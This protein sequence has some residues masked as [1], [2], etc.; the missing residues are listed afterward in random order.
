[1]IKVLLIVAIIGVNSTPAVTLNKEFLSLEDCIK[2]GQV[3]EKLY[4]NVKWK[5]IKWA[6]V[7]K[8][9]IHFNKKIK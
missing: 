9:G 6:C 1:M 7:S 2:I 3:Y 4:K 8:D 5:E